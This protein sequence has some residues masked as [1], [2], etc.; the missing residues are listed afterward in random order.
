MKE[1]LQKLQVILPPGDKK[2]IFG[3]FVLMLIA[4]ILEVIG[5]S[6]ILAF[7][8]TVSNPDTLFQITWLAPIL[9]RA[10]ITDAK[11][12]LT[13]G[14]ILLIVLFVLKNAYIISF[15]Y[16][17][18]HFVYRR[19]S[20][21]SSRL[22]NS[23][24]RAPYIYHL[25]NN[26]ARLVRNVT[27]ETTLLVHYIMLPLLVVVME[28]I[29]IISISIFLF[30]VEP[31]NTLIV[32]FFVGSSGIFFLRLV[33]KKIQ[34][35][36]SESLIER[37]TMIRR[38]NEG[39]GGIKEILVKNRQSWFINAFTQSIH[40]YAKAETYKNI[41][42][43]SARPVIETV[44]VAGM[45]LVALVLVWQGRGVESILPVLSLF[46]VATFKLMPSLDKVVSNSNVI[47]YYTYTLNS[48]H[49]DIAELSKIETP[50]HTNSDN[51]KISISST[52]SLQKVYF[53]YPGSE[54]QVLQ[55]VSLTIPKGAAIGF[56][57]P[58]GA[59]KSTIVD[60]IL[61]LLSIDSGQILVDGKDIKNT[62]AAWQKNI[63]YIPQTIFLADNT[64]R[65]NIAFG[66]NDNEINDAQVSRAI[67]MAQL[68]EFIA[69]LPQGVNTMVGERGVRLSGGQRQRIGIAR[70][71]YHDPEVLVM[72]E[73]TSSLDNQTEKY[74]ID[75]IENL[76]RDRTIIIVAHR[77]STVENCDNL[78]FIEKGHIKDSGTYSHI[79]QQNSE[80]LVNEKR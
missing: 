80:L 19:F 1:I 68:E 46:G 56:V 62:M 3:I 67:K 69:S 60:I 39:V 10:N 28:S 4:A 45:L 31:L 32:L 22:F 74:I 75:A 14:S 35:F 27:G 36:G 5:I 79:I 13:Y 29:M 51:K 41:F 48:I 2:K 18:S 20:A 55:D 49:D 9:Q 23:Y 33:K 47:R 54:K 58:S 65:N 71:L 78:F 8:S 26:S 66:L 72:D 52:L 21:I 12:L 37:E 15:Q 44:A 42:K 61:G 53:R 40:T 30:A 43:M 77:L 6:L 24:M 16:I 7:I 73:A 59:G 25:N 76:K 57:G 34:H 38:V 17:Q 64:I 63:G 50:I 70:A 11:G